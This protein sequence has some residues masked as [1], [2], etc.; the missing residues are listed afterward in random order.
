V[1]LRDSLWNPSRSEK[2]FACNLT[3]RAI[4]VGHS[5]VF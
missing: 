5:E 2:H 4:L 1:Q 3:Q